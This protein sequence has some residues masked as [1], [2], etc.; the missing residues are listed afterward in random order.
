MSV[1][2]SYM[3]KC[4]LS[5]QITGRMKKHTWTGLESKLLLSGKN[6]FINLRKE[7]PLGLLLYNLV[8]SGVGAYGTWYLRE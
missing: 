2:A 6:F 3:K 4:I 7:V 8:L 1:V 5:C